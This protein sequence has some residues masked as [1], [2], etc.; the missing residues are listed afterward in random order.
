MNKPIKTWDEADKAN[1]RT[2]LK[3]RKRFTSTRR[4]T[5]GQFGSDKKNYVD[6]GDGCRVI[7][8]REVQ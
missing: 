3:D 7:N 5:Y 6:M 2:E 8:N 4:S 1:A